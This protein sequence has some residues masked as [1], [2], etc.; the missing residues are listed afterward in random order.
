MNFLG[1]ERGL[2][3][4]EFSRFASGFA[5]NS[6]GNT[7]PVHKFM[8][9]S[10]HFSSGMSGVV[11]G[12]S[13]QS[14]PYYLQPMYE[15]MER[16]QEIFYHQQQ[17]YQ[18]QQKEAQNQISKMSGEQSALMRDMFSSFEGSFK[19]MMDT[20]LSMMAMNNPKMSEFRNATP[21]NDATSD[22]IK[23]KVDPVSGKI[24]R[25]SGD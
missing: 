25:V 4:S 19:T 9:S 18:G 23:V 11:N 24:T 17:A 22:T 10:P 2:L 15:L 14:L 1:Y 21:A 12:R 13:V 5:N 6:Y 16:Q 3:V 7:V 20:M 8:P